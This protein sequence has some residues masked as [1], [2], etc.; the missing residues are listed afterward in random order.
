MK[1]FIF[2]FYTVLT[3]SCQTNDSDWEKV[4]KDNISSYSYKKS[5]ISILKAGYTHSVSGILMIEYE[6]PQ[7]ATVKEKTFNYNSKIIPFDLSCNRYTWSSRG[8]T[9]YNSKGEVTY[10]YNFSE[11]GNINPKSGF[12]KLHTKVCLIKD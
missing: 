4:Y 2:L 11:Y 1:L 9:F 8:A 10:E 7:T 3:L 12:N 5:S 6:Y